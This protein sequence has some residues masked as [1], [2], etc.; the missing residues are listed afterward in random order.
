MAERTNFAKTELDARDSTGSF[1]C[2][3]TWDDSARP[4]ELVTTKFKGVTFTKDEFCERRM[5]SVRV[6]VSF[7][8]NGSGA[9]LWTC[10]TTK[11]LDPAFASLLQRIAGQSDGNLV[12]IGSADEL[13][14]IVGARKPL[15]DALDAKM[16]AAGTSFD[17]KAGSDEDA[18]YQRALSMLRVLSVIDEVDPKS[19]RISREALG[20]LGQ[21]RRVHIGLA[22][23]KLG[24]DLAKNCTL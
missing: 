15:R 22:L 24:L 5:V 6:D 12:F 3:S 21:A 4:T 13:P 14:I 16:L 1:Q 17:W 23:P 20:K 2:S 18:V 9:A 10:P 11:C 19:K 8:T 7:P